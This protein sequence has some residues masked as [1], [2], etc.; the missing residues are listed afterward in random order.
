MSRIHFAG[1]DPRFSGGVHWESVVNWTKD[2][3]KRL[4]WEVSKPRVPKGGHVHIHLGCGDI[5]FPGFINVDARPRPHVHFVRK[6]H[7][8]SI[9]DDD[10]AD[11]IYVCHCLEHIP[12]RKV[13]DV[14]AEWRRVLKPGGILRLSVPDFEL[15]LAIYLANERDIETIQPAL[16][17]GQDYAYNF[18]FAC[19]DRRYLSKQLTEAGFRDV[20]EWTNDGDLLKNLP[21]WSHR[22]L[23][24]RDRKFA[25]S[26]NLEACK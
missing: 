12:F 19:F 2:R 17:G 16:M 11:L 1:P 26:L 23:T 21:D 10:V 5:D 3:V 24:V 7:D 6:V 13:K 15:L 22:T 4:V 8:L 25:V 20:R 9:F 18:H 14:L